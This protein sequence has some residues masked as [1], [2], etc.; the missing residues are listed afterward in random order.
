MSVIYNFKAR[1]N[2]M[3]QKNEQGIA[4]LY[5]LGILALLTVMAL[6]F[7]NSSIF[8]QRAMAHSSAG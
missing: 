4:L 8:D 7:M 1:N 5:V 3:Y 6:A 2:I